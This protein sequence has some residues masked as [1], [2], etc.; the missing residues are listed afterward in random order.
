MTVSLSPTL[1]SWSGYSVPAL[2]E[3]GRLPAD[4]SRVTALQPTTRRL[5][6]APC[7]TLAALLLR[8]SENRYLGTN[9]TQLDRHLETPLMWS[10]N[11]RS[12]SLCVCRVS[13]KR[14]SG[15]P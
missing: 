6:V 1:A 4:H 5:S 11:V 15:F 9:P 14:S 10:F 13:S 8:L 7:V 12:I 3:R 2:V